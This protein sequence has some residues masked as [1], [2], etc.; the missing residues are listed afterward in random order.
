[1]S[2]TGLQETVYGHLP[3]G[4]QVRQFTLTNNQGIEVAILSYGGIITSIKTPNKFGQSNNIVL[5]LNS[6]EEYLNCPVYFGHIIG[7][8]AGRIR[9]GQFQ[10]DDQTF[11]LDHNHG[12]HHIH[13]GSVGFSHRNWQATTFKSAEENTNN[14]KDRKIET[15]LRLK[16]SSSDGDQGY[17][18]NLSATVDYCLTD[19][20]ILKIDFKATTDKATHINLTQHPYFNLC[21]TNQYGQENTILGHEVSIKAD[22]FLELDDH[23]LPTGRKLQVNNTAFDFRSSKTID[24]VIDSDEPQLQLTQGY[25]HGFIINHDDNKHNEPIATV[26]EPNSGRRLSINSNQPSLQFYTGN[27]LSQTR[28]KKLHPFKNRAGFCIEPQHFPDSPNFKTFPSTLLK[29]NDVYH[30]S[31]S[32]LFDTI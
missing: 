10:I 21:D 8:F 26:T 18:G 30:H 3:N 9:H 14:G 2:T 28:E 23:Y 16:L 22:Q 31:S 12:D 27:F 20:N 5:G 19:D 7:R 29:P 24:S 11:K 4:E 13:G 6:L 1:M 15:V 32:F 25:D 17:P